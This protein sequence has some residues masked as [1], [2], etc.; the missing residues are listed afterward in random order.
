[1]VVA[2]PRSAPKPEVRR[3]RIGTH[4]FAVLVA[5]L[6]VPHR[7]GVSARGRAPVPAH[8]SDHVLAS[9]LAGIQAESPSTLTIRIASP[10]V[11]AEPMGG[12]AKV[13]PND[14]AALERES[15]V[16][17]RGWKPAQRGAAKP[18]TGKARI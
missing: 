15:E 9:A 17:H 6:K 18:A 11:R 8:G 10:S 13:P 5:R 3:A 2:R 12:R 4:A 1:M 14:H 7:P 16:V